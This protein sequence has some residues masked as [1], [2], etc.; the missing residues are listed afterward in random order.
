M[1]DGRAPEARV[2]SKIP[3]NVRTHINAGDVYDFVVRR[4]D[5]ARF[6]QESGRRIDGGA[7]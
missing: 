1:I 4:Q 3:T 5:I 6:D 7:T 2:I